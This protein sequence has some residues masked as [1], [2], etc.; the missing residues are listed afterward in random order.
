MIQCAV[1]LAG[2]LVGG[3]QADEGISNLPARISANSEE[4]RYNASVPATPREI[5]QA[6]SIPTAGAAKEPA[7]PQSRERVVRRITPRSHDARFGKGKSLR[8][9]ES[10][11]GADSEKKKE[12][13][14]AQAPPSSRRMTWWVT[15]ALGLIVVL[16]VIFAAGRALRSVVPGMGGL[17]MSGPIH[18]LHRTFITPKQSACLIRC[19]DR[20]LLIGLSGDRMQTLAEITDPKEI[21]FLKGACMQIRP[22]STTQA[23]RDI[24]RKGNEPLVGK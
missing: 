21:D 17:E 14:K 7:A 9:G 22:R 11:V 8:E 6:P 10:E 15:T 5:P 19:G 12:D 1:L 20:I 4:P 23:F 13:D 2:M 3:G 24:F 18:V 16:A